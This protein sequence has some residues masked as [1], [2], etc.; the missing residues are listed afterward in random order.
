LIAPKAE[1]YCKIEAKY[2][3][4]KSNE[5]VSPTTSSMPSGVERVLSIESV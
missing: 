2:S 5:V 3:A 4:E 1:G